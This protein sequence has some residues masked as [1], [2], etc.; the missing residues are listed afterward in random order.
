[1]LHDACNNISGLKA[2]ISNYSGSG[3]ST[4]ISIL[5]GMVCPTTGYAT[6]HN[7]DVSFDSDKARRFTG[8]CTQ[9]LSYF[10]LLTVRQHVVMC[11]R[12]RHFL[13]C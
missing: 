5:A 11:Y 3:K 4:L 8:L 9:K 1:M 13:F 2:S 7:Y 12:V 10:N 6:I